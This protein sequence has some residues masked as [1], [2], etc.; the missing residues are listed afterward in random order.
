[1][2]PGDLIYRDVNT[3]G[4]IDGN[5][6]RPIGY[7]RDRN[8]ILNLGLNFSLAWQGF[9]FKADFSGGSMYSYNQGWEMRWPYQNTGNLLRQ[10]YDDRWHRQDPF[11]LDSPWVPG[12]YPALR[13]NEG[14]HSNYNRNSDFWLTNVKYLRSRTIEFGY[15]IPKGL[16]D[17]IKVKRARI[18]VNG[19]NLFSIDNVSKLGVEPEILD[20]NGLQFPQNRFINLGVNLSF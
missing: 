13:F 5:D 7:P 9:D 16:L 3:D 8:P 1:L 12:T 6:Q 19:Y 11:N 2:L 10:F 20:E 15:S 18:Y 4:K 14:G 17:K